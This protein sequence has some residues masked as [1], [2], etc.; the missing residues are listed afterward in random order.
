MAGQYKLAPVTNDMRA[1]ASAIR[2]AAFAPSNR[3]DVYDLLAQLTDDFGPRFSGSAALESAIA[4]IVARA[5]QEAAYYNTTVER[6]LVPA[7]VRGN[8]WA[9]LQ[10]PTRN[11]TLHFVGLGMSNGTQGRVITAPVIV[12]D[13]FADLQARGADAIGKIVVFDVPFTD[14]GTTVQTRE[15]AGVWAA[16]VGAVAALIRS[17]SSYSMQNTHTGATLTASVPAGAVSVEDA[18]QLKRLYVRGIPMT[19]SLYMEAHQEPDRW[20]QNIIMDLRG[21]EKPDEFVV[22][23][24]HVDSWDIAEGAMD[25]GGGIMSAWGAIRIL[26]HLGIRASRTIRAVMWVNEENGGR[27]GAQYAADH[28]AEINS[29]SIAIETDEGAFSPWALSFTGHQAAQQQLVILSELIGPL[30]AGNVTV[31]GGGTDIDPMCQL[32]VPCASIDPRDPRA[33]N[34]PNNPCLGMLSSTDL[35]NPILGASGGIPDGYFWFHHSDADTIDRMDPTQL[36]TMAAVL[37]TWAVAIGDLP[38]LLPRDG[39]LATTAAEPQE[40]ASPDTANPTK[41]AVAVVACIVVLVGGTVAAAL[42]VR[43]RRLQQGR[44]MVQ[45]DDLV[46]TDYS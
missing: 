30:G 41:V 22:F 14:Y 35:S 37:A 5:N 46:D 20:S 12:V 13:S 27:G 1:K 43:R 26:S 39:P 8:E 32:Q 10:T 25:D 21:T 2:A 6:V 36:Q 28:M 45:R 4:W 29:T 3:S 16:S 18:T 23:G 11:K 17:V 7:W 9:T 44:R 38:A 19:I 15:N 40:P 31:G 24:G 34:Y 33:T 42:F